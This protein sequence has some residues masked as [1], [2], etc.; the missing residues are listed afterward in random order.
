MQIRDALSILNL[1]Q[2]PITLDD[3]K[4]AYRRAAA[5]YHP[6]HNPAGLEMMKLV[7]IAYD[8]LKDYEGDIESPE[9][10]NDYGEALNA[11]LNAIVGLG[12]DIEICGAWIWVSGD[13]RLH[14]EI[15]KAAGYLWA[16]IKKRWYFRPE[17]YKSRNRQSWSMDKIRDAYGSQGMKEESRQ[18]ITA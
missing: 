13:T 15:L 14:K 6:D 18:E 7:N 5:K 11:A 2:H 3:I 1:H 4:M 12:L 17:A 8:T 10:S 9:N 16:P